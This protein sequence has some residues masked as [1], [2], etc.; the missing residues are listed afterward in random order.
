MKLALITA[1]AAS[2]AA[3]PKVSVRLN[4]LLEGE[5]DKTH[6][7]IF[8][9]NLDHEALARVGAAA[10]NKHQAVDDFLTAASLKAEKELAKVLEGKKFQKLSIGGA[11]NIM[12]A[13][14]ETI[15]QLEAHA[16]VQ[17]IDVNGPNDNKLP[18][19]LKKENHEASLAANSTIEWGVNTVGAPEIWQYFTGK[20][21][22][23][24]SI[25]TG[26]R[27]THEAFKANYRDDHGWF[28]PYHAST[29]PEDSG[30]HGSHTVGTMVGKDGLGV[31]PDAQWIACMGL[32]E[33]SGDDAS[34]LKCAEFMLCPTKPDGTDRDCT[35]GADVVNNSWGSVGEYDPWYENV[36][37]AW[38]AAN[39][40][41]IFA[42]G[43][44]GPACGSVSWPGG[45]TSVIGVGAIGSY[46]DSP[47]DLAFFSG[48]GPAWINGQKF[49][50]PDV[51]A[52]GFFTRSAVNTSDTAYDY[53]AGTSMAAPHVAGVVALL[54]SADKSLT[55]EQVYRFL[56]KTTDQKMMITTEPDLWFWGG[57][58]RK[59]YNASGAP[60]CDSISDD[61]WPNNRFGYGRVNVGTI[62]R[63]GSL[64][65]TRRDG[66]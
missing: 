15:K 40:I 52:P 46:E 43:N 64:H 54:K 56:T 61:S 13:D 34:L 22:V 27:G 21:V 44:E 5:S 7:V 28:D 11:F 32:N 16:S 1:F 42:N 31:A 41:P 38:K 45:Y 14:P 8:S 60:N 18:K 57:A 9:Y 10:S 36:V 30:G 29:F 49:V 51:S 26:V 58:D 23:I 25:D 66:C 33:E 37:A 6:N 24:G 35:K 2:A 62:L 63:D 39:I 65:D 4:K 12:N 17:Y 53:Y 50:K 55:Y 3:H 59:K 20:G 47:T 19:F 48:K